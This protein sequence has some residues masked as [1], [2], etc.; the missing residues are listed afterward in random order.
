MIRIGFGGPLY[1]NYNKETHQNP[2]LII[3][4]PLLGG[5]YGHYNGEVGLRTE[6]PGVLATSSQ[7]K[8]TRSGEFRVL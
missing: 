8:E 7:L 3:Q 6:G 5:L 2:I 1:Y 4:A